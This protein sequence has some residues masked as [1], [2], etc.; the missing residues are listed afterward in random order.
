MFLAVN[1]CVSLCG[2][3]SIV[4]RCVLVNRVCLTLRGSYVLLPIKVIG[5][6][7]SVHLGEVKLGLVR[8]LRLAQGQKVV[9]TST[10]TL[11][12]QVDGEPWEQ[13][14]S[15]MVFSHHGQSRVLH[16]AKQ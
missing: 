12:V 15:T 2:C 7:G 11:P 14:P 5:V 13:P 10:H 1:L 3:A 4:F 16:S 9:V 6:R 8:G